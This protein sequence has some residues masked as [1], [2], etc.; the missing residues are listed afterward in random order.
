MGIFDMIKGKSKRRVKQDDSEP[1]TV[2]RPEIEPEPITKRFSKQ[3]IAS[4]VLE[5]VSIKD[6]IT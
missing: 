3:E 4:L 5:S 6:P 1:V 2:R